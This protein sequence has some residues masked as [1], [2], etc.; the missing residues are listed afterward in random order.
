[1]NANAPI[2]LQM[3]KSCVSCTQ[4]VP[5]GFDNDKHCPFTHWGKPK[6][7]T[8]Y[9]LCSQHKQEVFATE[10]CS[11]YQCE[12]GVHSYPVPNRPHPRSPMQ[13]QLALQ[14]GVQ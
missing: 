4:Y 13:E 11:S 6:T 9:G 14:G 12:P 5:Q 2:E 3:P 8:P 7:R 10:I 1:M